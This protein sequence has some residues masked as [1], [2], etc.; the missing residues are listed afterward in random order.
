MRIKI[1]ISIIPFLLISSTQIARAAGKSACWI[2]GTVRNE[3]GKPLAYANVFLKGH[4]EGAMSDELGNFSFSTGAKGR[5]TLVCSYIGY[6]TYERE[7]ALRPGEIIQLKICLKSKP[8]KGKLIT[9]TASSF[10]SADREGMTLSSM[11]VVTTPGA[12]AD[13]LWAIKTFPGVAQVEE[14]A[15]MFVRGG[16]VSETAMFL[17]G[18][19]LPHPYRYESPTGGF[20]GTISPFLLKGTYFSS[21]G[22]SARYGNALSGALAME[23]QDLPTKSDI[24]LGLGLAAESGAIN[25]PLVE[26]R[27]GFSSSGNISN[28]KAMF[29]LNNSQERFSQYPYAHDLNLNLIYRYSPSGYL[30]LFLFHEMDKLGVEVK[31]PLYGGFYNGKSLNYLY[32]LKFSDLLSHRILVQGNLAYTDFRRESHLNRLNIDSQ[33]RL[34]QLRL[35]GEWEAENDL[36]LRGGVSHISRQVLNS[37][38]VPQDE[39]DLSPNAP[40]YII[41]THYQS[42]LTAVFSEGEF[43]SFLG[44][45]TSGL[46]GEYESISSQFTLDPRLSLMFPLGAHSGLTAAWGIYHQYPDPKYYDPNIGNPHLAAMTSTH[47]ILG[48]EYHQ[49]DQIFRFEVYLKKYSKLLLDDSTY[50]YT[51]DGY[52]YAKGIDLFVKRTYKLASGWLSYS[53]LKSRRRWKEFPDLRPPYF[54]I[55]HNLTL[56]A[57][58]NPTPHLGLGMTYRY[59]TG[60]PYTPAPGQ[61][62]TKRVPDYEK[63]DISLSY[64]CSLFE[65]NITVL[66]LGVSNLLGRENIFGYRYSP[67]YSQ[68]EPV[69]SSFRRSVYFGMSLNI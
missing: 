33:D 25:L 42:R 26:G 5:S 68:R 43:Y 11:D 65:G 35:S 20:F 62:N 9:I 27:L 40:I 66:Y 13:L 16:D 36:T 49:G 52:G 56:V 47:R 2:K 44:R 60:K 1:A 45:F 29:K 64:L 15:G 57:K 37:G 46:R 63:L 8:I 51:N 30:K 14:G 18:A 48:Y 39:E 61:Y 10:T 67:D 31:N 55:T 59:A 69:K 50:N 53:Y 24:T 34:N 3:E 58:Y 41:D 54:D 28:T 6:Q 19:I 32:N 4:M 38:E 12:A 7:I 21:G 17:D 23:S 22:F